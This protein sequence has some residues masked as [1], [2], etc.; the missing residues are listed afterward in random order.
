MYFYFKIIFLHYIKCR[1]VVCST[2]HVAYIFFCKYIFY[3]IIL[4]L[5]FIFYGHNKKKY[6]KKK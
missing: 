6:V 3:K 5:I 1:T 2:E 4:H